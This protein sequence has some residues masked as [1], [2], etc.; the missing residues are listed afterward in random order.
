MTLTLDAIS[1]R[2]I[3]SSDRTYFVRSDGNNGNDG[4]TDSP[5]GAFKDWRYAAF[6][7]SRLDFNDRTVTLQAGDEDGEI[8]FK[9][10]ITLTGLRGSGTL[11]IRGNGMGRTVWGSET[12]DSWTLSNTGLVQVNFEAGKL[13]SAGTGIKVSYMSLCNIVTDIEFGDMGG[14]AIWVHDNQAIC[15]ILYS[16]IVFTGKMHAFLLIQYGHCFLEGA[17]I[18]GVKGAQFDHGFITMYPRGSAQVIANRVSGEAKG[19]RF[20]LHHLSL[21]NLGSKAPES[22]LLGDEPGTSDATSVVS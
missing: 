21:L 8:V 22:Q 7:A 9:N 5:Q 19:Q 15:Q 3:L 18:T 14:A 2:E 20:N 16:R 13:Q 12:G 11:L 17:E 10:N 4:L 1:F 6:V